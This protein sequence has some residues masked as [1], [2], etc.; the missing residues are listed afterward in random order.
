MLSCER[1][2]SRTAGSRRCYAGV[3]FIVMVP[4]AGR[5]QR[6]SERASWQTFQS[7]LIKSVAN[8]VLF[9][10][11]ILFILKVGDSARN[12]LLVVGEREDW[13]TMMTKATRAQDYSA[14][15]RSR[16]STTP[17]LSPGSPKFN[18]N[19]SLLCISIACLCLN[20]Y[21]HMSLFSFTVITYIMYSNNSI[22][23]NYLFIYVLPQQA[24]E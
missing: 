23:F 6:M 2:N 7:G 24:K 5:D 8:P 17:F 10:V 1:N 15:P 16:A 11:C 20:I 21:V 4:P 3:C 12:D 18:W 19:C 9:H 22:Q 13:R 14:V